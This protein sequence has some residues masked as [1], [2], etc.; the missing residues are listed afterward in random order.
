[1]DVALVLIL[2]GSAVVVGSYDTYGV[3]RDYADLYASRHGH[4]PPLIDWF[5]KSDADAEV[6]SLRRRHRNL[7]ILVSGLAAAAV[8]VALFIRNAARG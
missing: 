8:I 5:F 2:I 1:M 3:Q 7:Y 4:I 6:E